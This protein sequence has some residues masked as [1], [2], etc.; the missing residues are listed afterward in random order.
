MHLF[1]GCS[2]SRG[3]VAY[4]GNK[5]KGRDSSCFLLDAGV[6][7]LQSRLRSWGVT[8]R[9]LHGCLYTHSHRDHYRPASHSFL[10]ESDVPVYLPAGMRISL[11]GDGLSSSS[12]SAMEALLRPQFHS[13]FGVYEFSCSHDVPCVGY[14]VRLIDDS[15][16]TWVSD[17]VFPTRPFLH[18]LEDTSVLCIDCNYDPAL[19]DGSLDLS[20]LPE[21]VRASVSAKLSLPEYPPYVRDRIASYGH[22]DTLRV[23]DL[24]S[25]SPWIERVV[26]L[27]LSSRYQ[28]LELL[29]WRISESGI[30]DRVDFVFSDQATPVDISLDMI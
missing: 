17:T 8:K 23:L 14:T 26:L 20:V 15:Y 28:D 21:C 1:V 3:N 2:G 29:R 25:A 22:L 18:A 4:V 19:L 16:M 13:H 5:R 11:C 12:L 24:V 9:N 27:H 6:T 10:V 30:S 7:R